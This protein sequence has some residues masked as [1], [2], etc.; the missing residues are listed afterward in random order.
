CTYLELPLFPY[1][2]LFRSGCDLLVLR[3]SRGRM[4]SGTD[5]FADTHRDSHAGF[6]HRHRCPPWPRCNGSPPCRWSRWCRPLLPAQP[7]GRSEEHT[8]ELQSRE[9]L[10][11]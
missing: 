6:E 5:T 9:N 3:A 4:A 7:S 10:V 2:T 8:S 11:C 1:T